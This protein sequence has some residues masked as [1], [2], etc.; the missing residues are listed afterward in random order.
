MTVIFIKPNVTLVSNICQLQL[1]TQINSY[2]SLHI[3]V[4]ETNQIPYSK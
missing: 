4:Y 2:L 1:Q 3:K